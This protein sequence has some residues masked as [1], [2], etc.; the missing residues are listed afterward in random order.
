MTRELLEL[1]MVDHA[2]NR[3]KGIK[4]SDAWLPACELITAPIGVNSVRTTDEQH[5]TMISL[6]KC[7]ASRTSSHL[8]EG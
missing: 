5:E 4:L 7:V 8:E 3:E 6:Y 2:L 1:L